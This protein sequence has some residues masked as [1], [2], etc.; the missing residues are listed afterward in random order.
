MAM[1]SVSY[2]V[3]LDVQRQSVSYCIKGPDGTIVREGKVEAAASLIGM[4]TRFG[5]R[6]LERRLGSDHLQ[7]LH[8][9]SPA[10]LCG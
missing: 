9:P 10:A 8:I 2:Y 4:G 1:R 3:G 6:S 5:Q 7:A